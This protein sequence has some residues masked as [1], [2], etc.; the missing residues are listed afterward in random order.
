MTYLAKL[1][2]RKV[3]QEQLGLGDVSMGL[4]CRH[5][6]LV[7]IPQNTCYNGGVVEIVQHLQVLAVFPEDSGMIPG[8]HVAGHNCLECQF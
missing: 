1:W 7:L 3:L 5:E 4:L 2:Q 6:G 8:T